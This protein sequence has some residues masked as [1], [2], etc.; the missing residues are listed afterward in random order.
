M[1]GTALACFLCLS[2]PAH[3]DTIVLK[4]GRRISGETV[5]REDGKVICET[6][7]GRIVL[8]ESL[9]ERIEK[10][11]IGKASVAHTASAAASLGLAPPASDPDDIAGP[12]GRAV[13]HD[14]GIDYELLSRLESKAAAGTPAAVADAT[15]ADSAASQFEF[16]RGH[17]DAALSYSERAL[18]RTPDQPTLLLNI[19]YLHLRAGEYRVASDYLE[20]AG[21]AAPDSPEVAKLNGWAYYG[22]NRLDQAVSEWKRAQQLRPDAEVAN[23]LEKAKRDLEAERDFREGESAHFIL[24]YNGGSAPDMARQVLITLEND[25]AEIGATLDSSPAQP[26]TVVLYTSEMFQDITRSPVWVGAL[27]D[28]RIRVPVQGLTGVTPELERVLKHELTHSFVSDKTHGR[29]PIWLQEGVAQWIEGKR[30][31]QA[32]ATL[33]ALYDRNEDPSLAALESTWMNMPADSAAIAYAWSLAVVEGIGQPN[34]ADIDRLLDRVAAE[35]SA[36]AATKN[37]LRMSYAE[38][39]RSTAE[40]LRR[41]YLRQR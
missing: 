29:A 18:A 2:V 9:V 4:N 16:A 38:L 12:I 22:L 39:S 34:A 8:P 1:V 10:N 40:Y 20:R 35:S 24:R 3:S 37:A 19:A 5:T 28:G 32:A 36:E 23:A 13:V 15:A 31:G 26:I 11:D 27:N 17:L 21:R 14:G 7:T 25:F 41:T 6:A 30:S 33:L